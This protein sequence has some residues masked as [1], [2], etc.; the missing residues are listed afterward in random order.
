[1]PGFARSLEE[2]D[3]KLPEIMKLLGEDG[4]LF[5]TA[6]HGCDPSFTSH[7]DHTRERV[8]LLVWGLGCEEGVNLGERESFADI[9]ATIL[10]ALGCGEKLDGTSFY[11]DIALN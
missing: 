11:R 8:P 7:T 9:S 10:E 4:L 1:M 6:D 3:K 5:I 2:F